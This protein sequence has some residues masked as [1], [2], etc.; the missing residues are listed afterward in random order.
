MEFTGDLWRMEDVAIV[1]DQNTPLFLTD[2]MPGEKQMCRFIHCWL[3][4]TG[5]AV[6]AVFHC[7]PDCTI[8]VDESFVSGNI[9]TE[10]GGKVRLSG[11]DQPAGTNAGDVAYTE[12][13]KSIKA[14]TD[15][16]TN[17]DAI[18]MS[19]KIPAT[20]ATG[21]GADA[22]TLLAKFTGI[23][24]LA[25]WLRGL[26]RKSAM[27]ATAKTEV[28]DGG[29]TYDE[30]TDSLEAAGEKASGLTSQQTRD[31]MALAIGNN[32]TVASGSVDYKLANISVPS[33]DSIAAATLAKPRLNGTMSL[34]DELAVMERLIAKGTP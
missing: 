7:G 27:D 6:D 4:S 32:V 25:K 16:F 13:G 2:S 15:K 33:A 19:K 29:G 12:P 24:L 22:A 10:T 11:T 5:T 3:T 21:D 23:T 30:A 26:F 34:N 8:D 31:A 9:S 17:L 1:S 18:P 14:Q 28:N 20:V